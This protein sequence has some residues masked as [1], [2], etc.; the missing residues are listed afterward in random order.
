MRLFPTLRETALTVLARS[1]M[2]LS[3]RRCPSAH[4]LRWE[5][6]ERLCTNRRLPLLASGVLQKGIGSW[7]N[8][9]CRTLF[10]LSSN[11]PKDEK[12][13]YKTINARVAP[14]SWISPGM[15]SRI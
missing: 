9:A 7:I 6:H 1:A 8:R 5:L 2:P 13:A 3:I 4:F 11:D 14:K 15:V 12:I 10:P